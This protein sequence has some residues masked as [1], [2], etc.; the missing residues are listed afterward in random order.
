MGEN[1]YYKKGTGLEYRQ[2]AKFGESPLEIG[3]QGP[4]L[5]KKKD[6]SAAGFSEPG[7]R[8]RRMS[9]VGVTVEVRF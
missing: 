4:L 2:G 7:M 6:P 9:G 8:Q 3:V 1:V 5:R